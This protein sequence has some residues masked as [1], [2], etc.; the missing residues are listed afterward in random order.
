[1]L[2]VHSNDDGNQRLEGREILVILAAKAERVGE[3]GEFERLLGLYACQRVTSR[4]RTSFRTPQRAR[5]F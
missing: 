4:I 3:A 2:A 5:E 1:M